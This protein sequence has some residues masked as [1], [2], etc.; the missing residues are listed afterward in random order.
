MK[1]KIKQPTNTSSEEKSSADSISQ[2]NG[3][4]Q[5]NKPSRLGQLVRSA[6]TKIKRQTKQVPLHRIASKDTSLTFKSHKKDTVGYTPQTHK[7][8]S[9]MT[10]SDVTFKRMQTH[11]KANSCSLHSTKMK[12]KNKGEKKKQ[13]N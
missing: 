10:Q 9:H 13:K 6:E 5:R 3:Y 11:N 2:R 12:M 1:W 4:L 7:T 8:L